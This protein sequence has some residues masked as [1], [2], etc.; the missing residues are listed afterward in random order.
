M[1]TGLRGDVVIVRTSGELDLVSAPG[2]RVRMAEAIALHTPPCVVI[3]TADLTFC[4]STGLSV[5][6]GALNAIE[7]AGGRLAISGV[8][9]QLAR[10]LKITGLDKKFRIHSTIDSAVKHLIETE[11]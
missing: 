7:A 4:D 2:F 3:D 10:I 1:I 5:L 9:G 11:D 6:A 8:H